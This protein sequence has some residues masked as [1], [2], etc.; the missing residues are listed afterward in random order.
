[1]TQCP[2]VSSDWL[3]HHLSDPHFRLID[4]SW[5]MPAD[6]RDAQQEY[7]DCHIGAAVFFDIDLYAAP[8]DLPHMMPGAAAFSSFAGA[9]GIAQTDTI[10]VYDTSGLFS[11]ARVWWMFKQFGALSVFVLDGGLRKWI[12]EGRRVESGPVAPEPALFSV[13]SFDDAIVSAEQVQESLA[14]G[15]D[16]IYDAR[17]WMRFSAQEKESRP[18]LRSGHIPGSKSL[19]FLDLQKDGCLKPVDEL[20][21]V[22]AARGFDPAKPVITTCGSGVTAAVIC[23]ALECIG[24]SGAR[25]YD[26]SWSEWGGREDLPVATGL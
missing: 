6:N 24:V 25:I 20:Q 15:A 22:F 7:F 5:H 12:S 23:L 8:S 3:S 26:G 13:N 14:S 19:P 11:A 2:L 4:A 1:M 10:V 17:S 16:Q 9:L 21:A 18:G